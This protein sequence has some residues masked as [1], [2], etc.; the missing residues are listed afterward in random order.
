MPVQLLGDE[1]RITVADNQL[2]IDGGDPDTTYTVRQIPP[3]VN[4]ALSKKHT[5]TPI[6][7]QTGHREQNV[8]QLALID[9]L[10]DYALVEWS[11][12]QLGGVDVDCTREHKLCL[13][14]PRKAALIGVAGLNQVTQA[15]KA[16]SF[17]VPPS[18]L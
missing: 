2:G 12:I 17:R 16:E 8:D 4:R 13:D 6:N 5:E 11:G 3:H 14:Y 10:L 15:A 1:N 7:R 18:V 9:D